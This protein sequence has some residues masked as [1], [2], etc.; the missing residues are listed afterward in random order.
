ADGVLDNAVRNLIADGVTVAIAA[1]N[2]GFLGNPEDACLASPARVAEAITVGASDINDARASFSNTGPC[3]DLFGPGV[4]ITSAWLG[5]GTNTISGTSMATP[6]VAGVAAQFLETHRRATPA[7]VRTALFDK[8]T[9]DIITGDGAGCF[10]IILFC[11]P[12][13]PNNHLIHTDF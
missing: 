9:K 11:W 4:G 5:G 8:S 3:I 13:T 1:G 12:A 2:G 10:L 6:H 7:R